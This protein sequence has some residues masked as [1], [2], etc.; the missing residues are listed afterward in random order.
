MMTSR[1]T[2]LLVGYVA[3]VVF[4]AGCMPQQVHLVVAKSQV[5]PEPVFTVIPADLSSGE[6]LRASQ[7]QTCLLSYG[8]RVVERPAVKFAEKREAS[9]RTRATQD[10]VATFPD[11][12]ADILV[13]SYAGS[14]RLKVLNKSRGYQLVLSETYPKDNVSVACGIV[15]Y[16]LFGLDLVDDRSELASEEGL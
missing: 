3:S 5:P 16:A 9:G 13:L 2:A 6:L 8:V 14:N 10:I 11:A 1:R 12:N 4:A 7:I 15:W